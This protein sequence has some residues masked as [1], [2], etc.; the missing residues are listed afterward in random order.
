[1]KIDKIINELKRNYI[2][3]SDEKDKLE[4]EPCGFCGGEAKVMVCDPLYGWC[5]ATVLCSS[6]GACGPRAGIYT[7]K[8]GQYLSSG[9][10]PESLEHGIAAAVCVWNE[11]V[12][13]DRACLR[14]LVVS[15]KETIA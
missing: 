15:D 7:R 10:T 8:P 6:C 5:G 14:N 2:W 13:V 11:R 4:L 3:M 1:M 9:M 12:V